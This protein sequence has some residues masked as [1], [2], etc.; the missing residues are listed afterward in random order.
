MDN[1]T[2]ENKLP[3]DF[4]KRWVE[5]L[6]S[7]EYKQ[8]ENTLLR[9][10]KFCCLGVACVV[11]GV[12]DINSVCSYGFIEFDP[13]NKPEVLKVP[14]ILRGDTPVTNVLASLNDG[15]D[16]QGTSEDKKKSFNE[17]ADYIEKNL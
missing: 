4:K 11:A 1:T 8:G 6:R 10:G 7:G 13:A 15:R 16:E 14:D 17:I 9:D 3:E 2:V 5:A 12:Q